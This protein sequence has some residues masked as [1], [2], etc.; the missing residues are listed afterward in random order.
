MFM[1]AKKSFITTI[2]RTQSVS[3]EKRAQGWPRKLPFQNL[4]R[5]SEVKT[6]PS[7]EIQLLLNSSEHN[8]LLWNSTSPQLNPLPGS[9]SPSSFGSLK[10]NVPL[11]CNNNAPLQKQKGLTI[12]IK[13]FCLIMAILLRWFQTKAVHKRPCIENQHCSL[14]R[15]SMLTINI[16]IVEATWTLYRC[17]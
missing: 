12:F 5:R 17:R 13:S 16:R 15:I 7:F 3:R 10:E 11:Q 1:R 4:I 14:S 6:T 8:I 2:S 9:Q